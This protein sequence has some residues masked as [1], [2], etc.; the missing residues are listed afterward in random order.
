[1]D[2]E[3][4]TYPGV[5]FV[6]GYRPRFKEMISEI[7]DGKESSIAYVCGPQAIVDQVSVLTQDYGILFHHETFEL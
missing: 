1:M 6:L 4:K 2:D 7:A 3:I 5:D